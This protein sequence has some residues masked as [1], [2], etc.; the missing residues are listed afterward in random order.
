MSQTSKKLALISATSVPLTNI[1]G[2]KVARVPCIYYPIRFRESQEQVRAL[3]D[4]GSK[5]NAMSPAFVRKLDFHIQKTNIGAQKID[6]STLKTFGMV[7]ADFQME[8]KV[9]RPKFF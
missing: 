5:I 9:G 7:I 8:D 1:S 4:S 2:K 3:F 6:D